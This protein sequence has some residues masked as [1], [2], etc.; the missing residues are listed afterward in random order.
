MAPGT[1]PSVI[2][3]LLR[4]VV[5]HNKF[6]QNSAITSVDSLMH[7]SMDSNKAQFLHPFLK[8]IQIVLLK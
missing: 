2:Q 5:D 1:L 6:V 4:C 8:V 7:S 3:G